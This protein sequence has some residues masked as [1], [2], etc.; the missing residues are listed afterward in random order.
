VKVHLSATALYN[1]IA[2]FYNLWTSIK[3]SIC[4][5]ETYLQFQFLWSYESL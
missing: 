5:Y 3:Y 1:H 4:L 2:R